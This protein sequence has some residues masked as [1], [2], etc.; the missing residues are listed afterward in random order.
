M[1]GEID[2]PE[3]GRRE[4][5]EYS[6]LRSVGVVSRRELG[7]R[8]KRTKEGRGEAGRGKQEEEKMVCSLSDDLMVTVTGQVKGGA[9][10]SHSVRCESWKAGA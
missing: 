4:A 1:D 5:R 9:F 2:R 8:V 6:T 3:L 7:M 10:D